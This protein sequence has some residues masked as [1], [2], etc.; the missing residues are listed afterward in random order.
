MYT[1]MVGEAKPPIWSIEEEPDVIGPWM[2]GQPI[3]FPLPEILEYILEDS[4]EE[5]GLR[6]LFSSEAVP[7]MHRELAKVL[8]QVGVRNLELFPAVLIDPVRNRRYEDYQAFNLVGL[9]PAMDL[10]KT[11][12]MPGSSLRAM[13]TDVDSLAIDE[14]KAGGRLL[15]RLAENVSAVMAHPRVKEAVEAAGFED[16]RFYDPKH[17]AG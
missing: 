17:W 3:D 14:E 7:L 1:V 4:D 13:D 15:F 11:T 5:L 2:D 9:V 6:T 8:R 10:E 16:V 12:L